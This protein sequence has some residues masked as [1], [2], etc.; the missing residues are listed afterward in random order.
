MNKTILKVQLWELWRLTRLELLFRF[1]LPIVMFYAL[2]AMVGGHFQLLNV[3]ALFG[4]LLASLTSG[5]W[6]ASFRQIEGGGF[7]LSLGYPRPLSSFQL[8]SVPL[9]WLTG[10]NVLVYLALATA[11]FQFFGVRPVG[12]AELPLVLF[13]SVAMATLSWATHR[14]GERVL[15]AV[16]LGGGAVF[17]LSKRTES[18]EFLNPLTLGMGD[19]V[20]RSEGIILLLMT[21]LMWIAAIYFLHLQRSGEMRPSRAAAKLQGFGEQ[22][23][24]E[25]T[26]GFL[27]P[28]HASLWFELRR[29]GGRALYVLGGGLVLMLGSG[30]LVGATEMT[31]M[32]NALWVASLCITPLA[33]LLVTN[34]SVLGLRYRGHTSSLSVFEATQPDTVGRNVLMKTGISMGLTWTGSMVVVL[35]ALGC[36]GYFGGDVW[37]D[38]YSELID[39]MKV[40]FDVAVI[41]LGGL[42]TALII[43][44]ALCATAALLTMSF[45]YLI[46]RAE[47]H[48]SVGNALF[49]GVFIPIM[50]P[51]LGSLFQWDLIWVGKLGALAWGMSLVV[52][53]LLSLW[54]CARAGHYSVA[55]LVLVV[56]SWG[57]LL[58]ALWGFAVN[59]SIDLPKTNLYGYIL[60]A[61]LLCVPPASL[62]WASLSMAALRSR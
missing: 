37:D 19:F 13:A 39:A 16:L 55:F 29:A 33:L 3:V 54:R 1:L 12:V 56:L 61:G 22:V 52:V 30:V 10:S 57:G 9:L 24:A 32:V 5:L 8:V 20:T 17:W 48:R 45:G 59:T 18:L 49:A 4:I 7:S 44:A 58:A 26:T 31:S 14:I 40:S 50:A 34:E 38:A 43:F 2:G 35:A 36:T 28:L 47:E 41:W 15:A 21:A 27:G 11:F 25:R 51:I 46:P 6:L 53:A 60:L 62:A 23:L 42:L